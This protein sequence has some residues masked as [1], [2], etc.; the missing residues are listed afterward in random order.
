MNPPPLITDSDSFGFFSFSNGSGAASLF[1]RAAFPAIF[2]FGPSFRGLEGTFFGLAGRGDG[3]TLL[4]F[5]EC[6]VAFRISSLSSCVEDRLSWRRVIRSGWHGV[7]IFF[8]MRR[9]CY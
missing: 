2:D 6:V 4:F 7:G 1:R 5:G 8:L 9:C 3:A